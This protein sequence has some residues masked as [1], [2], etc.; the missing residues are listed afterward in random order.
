MLVIGQHQPVAPEALHPVLR[1]Q[2]ACDHGF[3]RLLYIKTFDPACHGI[4]YDGGGVVPYHAVG[5][6]AGELPD[7]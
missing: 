1:P 7:G 4:G 2:G 3:K 6:I 5:L